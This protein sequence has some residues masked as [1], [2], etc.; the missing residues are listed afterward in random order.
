MF[1]NGFYHLYSPYEK[2]PVLVYYY[3]IPETGESGFG[4]NL[5]DGGGFLPENDLT[6]ETTFT[7]V[8]LKEV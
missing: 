8:E 7:R 4:F 3:K 2:E 1:I 6:A 5:A